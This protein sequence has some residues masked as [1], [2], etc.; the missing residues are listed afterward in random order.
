MRSTIRPLPLPLALKEAIVTSFVSRAASVLRWPIN[1][2]DDTRPTWVVGLAPADARAVVRGAVGTDPYF[3]PVME[4]M[5]GIARSDVVGKVHD[6][7]RLQIY[8][9]ARRATCIGLVG[10]VSAHPDGSSIETRVG[11]IGFSRWWEPAARVWQPCFVAMVLK[12][13]ATFKDPFEIGMGLLLAF[14]VAGG[15][16]AS[17]RSRARCA[18]EEELPAIVACLDRALAPHRPSSHRGDPP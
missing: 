15:S 1:T 2:F 5:R 11:W 16:F 4:G 12:V 17:L 18:R 7:G 8:I 14:M 10:R 13:A 6:D 9:G 3:L